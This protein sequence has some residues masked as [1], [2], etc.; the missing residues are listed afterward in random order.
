MAVSRIAKDHPLG[1][2]PTI[3]ASFKRPILMPCKV[4]LR[5]RKEGES[6][7]FDVRDPQT[8]APHLIGAVA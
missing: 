1:H 8:G 3:E 5:V 6:V 4:K 7:E 2:S